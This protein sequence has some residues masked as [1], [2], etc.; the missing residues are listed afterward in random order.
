VGGGFG[1]DFV[2]YLDYVVRLEYSYNHIWQSGVYLHYK[3]G[4]Q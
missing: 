1:I 4:I 3:F 2:A